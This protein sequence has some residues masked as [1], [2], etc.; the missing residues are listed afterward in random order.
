MKKLA[1]ILVGTGITMASI[2]AMAQNPINARRY[3]TPLTEEERIERRIERIERRIE[4]IERKVENMQ[5]QLNL[6]DSQTREL[7]K[8]YSQQEETREKLQQTHRKA[9]EKYKSKCQNEVLRLLTPEQK[10]LYDSLQV[11]FG[12]KDR[13]FEN[14][15]GCRKGDCCKRHGK[16]RMSG[17]CAGRR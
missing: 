17:C 2:I 5:I 12:P 7:K 16:E 8:V 10:V 4:R 3:R 13:H 6:S 1:I 9:M 11:S 14:A 15:A